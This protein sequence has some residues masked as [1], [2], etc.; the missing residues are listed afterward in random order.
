[1]KGTSELPTDIGCRTGSPST[2]QTAC[3]GALS[4]STLRRTAIHSEE[5]RTSSSVSKRIRFASR[6]AGVGACVAGAGAA[7]VAAL[8]DIVASV[9]GGA[10]IEVIVGGR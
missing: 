10:A 7:V 5:R 9:V 1:M 4:V 6:S 2:A 8:P 3:I